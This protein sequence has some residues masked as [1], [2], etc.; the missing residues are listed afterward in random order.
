MISFCLLAGI[1]ALYC[2]ASD[3]EKKS[4]KEKWKKKSKKA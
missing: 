2:F 4:K 1:P 3:G